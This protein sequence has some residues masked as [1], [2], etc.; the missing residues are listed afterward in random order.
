MPIEIRRLSEV[1]SGLRS[2]F[3]RQI[4]FERKAQADEKAQHT[5][6]YVS[7]LKRLATQ[8]SDVRW[9]FE[10]TSGLSSLNDSRPNYR[11]ASV[12]PGPATISRV[13]LMHFN[14]NDRTRSP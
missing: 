13:A 1:V 5:W 7:I 11:P 6:E 14:L 3:K 4:A 8:L 2:G 10:I 9:G 12:I